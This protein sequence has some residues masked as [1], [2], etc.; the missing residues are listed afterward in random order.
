[1]FTESDFVRYNQ[2]RSLDISNGENIGIS[3]FVQGCNFHCEDCFNKETWDFNGGKEWDNMAMSNF[4][5]LADRP[6]IKRISVLGGEP[7]ANI[8]NCINVFCIL[9]TLKTRFPSKKIWLYTGCT[10]EEI[11]ADTNKT[12]SQEEQL[13]K[14][15]RKQAVTMCDVLVDGKYEK[16]LSDLSY[17]YAGSTNQR[18]I[19]VEKS[20]NSNKIVL[21]SKE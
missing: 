18:V 10:W 15:Y 3:L 16:A 14:K 19:D 1:M 12:D 13:F 8:D 21:W 17:P 20:L 11:F 6:Y 9:H 2:I 7:F 4:L 5:A